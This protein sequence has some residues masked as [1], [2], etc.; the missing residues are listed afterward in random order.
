MELSGGVERCL[1][2]LAIHYLDLIRHPNSHTAPIDRGDCSLD[3]F[4]W[5]WEPVE[6]VTPLLKLAE[7]PMNLLSLTEGEGGGSCSDPRL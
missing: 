2:R 4:A 1:E 7:L 5:R 3:C 6:I